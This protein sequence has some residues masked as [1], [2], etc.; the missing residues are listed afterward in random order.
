MNKWEFALWAVGLF[1][2]GMAA[3]FAYDA[4]ASARA[5]NQL[6]AQLAA[7]EGQA[8]REALALQREHQRMSVRPHYTVAF[9]SNEHGTGFLGENMGIGPAVIRSVELFF[10]DKPIPTLKA[11]TNR[12][13]NQ[14]MPKKMVKGAPFLGTFI[15]ANTSNR[16]YWIEAESSDFQLNPMVARL[17]AALPRTSFRICY[18]S[19]YDECWRFELP[20]APGEDNTTPVDVCPAANVPLLYQPDGSAP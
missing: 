19:L 9:S 5:A 12:V 14:G 18:C 7:N 11:Y 8:R 17:I 20:K 16:I 15:P 13:F 3:Y 10:D 2:A 4:A 6:T 1:I